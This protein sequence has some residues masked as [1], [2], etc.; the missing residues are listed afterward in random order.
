MTNEQDLSDLLKV[1][2]SDIIIDVRSPA[3][4]KHGHIRNAINMPL[5]D[6]EERTIVGTLYKQQSPESALIKGLEFVGP[7]M[8]AFASDFL[9][10]KNKKILAY[11]W[12]GG[13]RSNSMA[14]LMRTCGL[15]PTVISGGYKKYR[16][17]VLD[18]INHKDFKFYVIGGKTGTGKTEL[19]EGL[20]NKSQQVLDLEGLAHHKGS[21]FGHLGQALQPTEEQ[22]QNNLFHE[23]IELDNSKPIWV[24]NESR[25]V[26]KLCIP[27]GI[28]A[29]IRNGDLVNV[30]ISD[31]ERLEHVLQSYG[32]FPIE[33]L[34][35]SFKKIEKKLGN[36]AFNRTLEAL[37]SEDLKVAAMQAFYYYDKNYGKKLAENKSQSITHLDLTGFTFE[38][39]IEELLKYARTKG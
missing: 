4:F 15:N 33:N 38:Q 12:R 18:F 27:E 23:I 6:D 14:W 24:E 5:L 29:S 20:K 34:I 2:N 21:A 17:H 32:Q 30:E 35:E 11:C 1:A 7:K 10:M 36:L 8:K 25:M 22:F 37:Q 3:E 39:K 9:K 13:Q 31:E 26:G 19:L 16:T 28:W